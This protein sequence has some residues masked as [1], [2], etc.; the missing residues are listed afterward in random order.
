MRMYAPF[1][2]NKSSKIGVVSV[3]KKQWPIRK[4]AAQCDGKDEIIIVDSTVKI[5]IKIR[6]VFN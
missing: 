3:R 1:V 2:L 6:E 5:P 4:P